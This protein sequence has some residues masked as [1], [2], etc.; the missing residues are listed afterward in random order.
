[1]ALPRHSATQLLVPSAHD[2]HAPGHLDELTQVID[3][4][5]VDAILDETG[6]RERRV[7]LLP[8]RVVVQFVLALAF[9]EHS[10]YTAVLGQAPR[11]AARVGA[12]RPGASSLSRARRR[13]GSAPLRRLFEV[14]AGPVATRAQ[15]SSF[16]RGLRVVA[17]AGTTFSLP[18]EEA[19]TWRCSW[20][21]RPS[22]APPC[23]GP[24]S[25]SAS[26]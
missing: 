25:A 16:Y 11:E 6:S 2:V 12:R 15:T 24:S 21:S 20:P 22:P 8:S 9:F 4:Q 5:L 7:R 14:L 1:M 26:D 10:S 23:S 17:V 19:V 13:L 3:P 18:D